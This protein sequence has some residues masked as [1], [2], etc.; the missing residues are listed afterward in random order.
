MTPKP[1]TKNVSELIDRVEDFFRRAQLMNDVL[2]GE[3]NHG[4][5]AEDWGLMIEIKDKLNKSEEM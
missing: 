1:K 5:S 2:E 4:L 3:W